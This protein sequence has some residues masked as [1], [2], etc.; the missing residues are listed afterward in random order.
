MNKKRQFERNIDYTSFD[1]YCQGVCPKF[2]ENAKLSIR[3][4][5]RYE[6]KYDLDLTYTPHIKECSLLKEKNDKNTVCMLSC[7]VFKAYKN[8]H[9]Y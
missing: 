5:G 7:P 9:N 1:T 2:N 8:G 4:N 6:S 3:L